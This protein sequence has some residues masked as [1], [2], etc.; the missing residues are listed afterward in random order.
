MS[1]DASFRPASVRSRKRMVKPSLS[2]ALDSRR[3]RL[4]RLSFVADCD[5]QRPERL[6]PVQ[7]EEGVV[8]P[9]Q[10]GRHVVAAVLVLGMVHDA[11]GPMPA[12]L[13]EICILAD[14]VE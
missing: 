4:R 10:D 12:V 11:N 1:L 2:W 3:E 8:A 5:V 7:V 6:R 13:Q 9:R 14:L